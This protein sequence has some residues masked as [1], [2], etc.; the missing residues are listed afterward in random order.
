ME[1]P[2]DARIKD[3]S[4][5]QEE[6]QSTSQQST[7]T[8]ADEGRRQLS[9]LK[10]LA[11]D[12]SYKYDINASEKRS[13]VEHVSLARALLPLARQLATLVIALV[14]V[15]ISI[16]AWDHYLRA[17]WT[18]DGR[19]RVQVANV[20]PQVSGRIKELRIADNQF[21]H[22]GDILYV[23]DPFD[24]EVSLRANTAMLKQ[25]KSG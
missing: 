13:R 17:P 7:S 9:K 11:R 22:T 6:T 8:Q 23:I 18:R 1:I 2:V 5:Q 15:L 14:A 12:A 16:L 25:K 10:P 20:A 19:I 21:V 3:E 4:V 24:F